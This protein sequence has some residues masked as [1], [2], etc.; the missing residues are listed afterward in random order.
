MVTTLSVI[1]RKLL[2][3]MLVRMQ[4]LPVGKVGFQECYSGIQSYISMNLS[5]YFVFIAMSLVLNKNHVYI[6]KNPYMTFQTSIAE[7][8]VACRTVRAVLTPNK[9]LN[10]SAAVIW[11]LFKFLLV[12]LTQAA[13]S[14][15]D[16]F[17]GPYINF[18]KI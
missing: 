2:S 14:F 3:G 11:L 4:L 8:L 12:Q 7:R 9:N 10:A 13:A 18:F 6:L 17:G 16:S 15:S 1:G 5:L